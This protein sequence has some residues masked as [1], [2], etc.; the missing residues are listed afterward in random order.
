MSAV[1]EAIG[2]I[3]GRVVGGIDLR[4]SD[5]DIAVVVANDA[6]QIRPVAKVVR[7]LPSG[8]DLSLIVRTLNHDGKACNATVRVLLL[9]R[10]LDRLLHLGAKR[11][12]ISRQWSADCDPDRF[13]H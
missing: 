8:L 2:V 10:E 9:D 3:I 4:R 13:R 6:K 1:S 12:G 5:S 11:C 7:D